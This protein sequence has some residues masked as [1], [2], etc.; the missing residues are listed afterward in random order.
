MT[1]NA[2]IV[3]CG[4]GMAGVATAYEL[5][6]RRGVR[7]VAL[8]DEREPLTLTSDKGTQAYRNWWPDGVMVQLMERSIAAL[9]ELAAESGNA[10]GMEPRGYLYVARSPAS[11]VELRDAAVATSALGAGPLRGGDATLGAGASLDAAAAPAET[12]PRGADLYSGND[13][14]RTR[15]TFL[16]S[17]AA[18][19][20]H[21]RRAGW[22]DAVRLGRW[23][24]GRAR[25]HGVELHL[26]RVVGVDLAGDRVAGVR[27]A[28]GEHIA[29]PALVL[30]AGPLLAR[31]AALLPGVEMPVACELHSKLCFDD[32]RGALPRDAPLVIG[33]DPL[34]IDG[35]DL[36]AG[37]HA[38]PLDRG[39]GRP[40]V[41][42]LWSYDCAVMSQ[43][44][45]PPRFDPRFASMA[46]RGMAQVVPGFAAYAG[47]PPAGATV[48]G[49]YYCTTPDHRPLVGPLPVRGAFVAG[50]LGGYGIM[51]SPG[52]AELIASHITGRAPAEFAA[53]LD[54]GRFRG[55]ET[56]R[57]A[58]SGVL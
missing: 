37:V 5:A 18:A 3:I 15:F 14:V 58:A 11:A 6:V 32:V 47:T 38:R 17:D 42:V 45:L 51:S 13:A 10:F 24:L 29:T 4:A 48:D 57:R 26:D 19:A 16:A 53:A 54:P 22:M 39:D 50:G 27:L 33:C 55:G 7:R 40:R 9:E 36:P 2:D 30:A 43:P 52:V 34:Q 25:A 20:L 31:A 8:V 56:P 21:V 12:Y 49:G 1:S 44:A 41:L 35:V 28:S 23:L 46:L